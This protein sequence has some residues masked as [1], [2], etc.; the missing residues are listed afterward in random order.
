MQQVLHIPP[1]LR[2][3]AVHQSYGP[4]ISKYYEASSDVD[5]NLANRSIDIRSEYSS[6]VTEC[7]KALVEL[8]LIFPYNFL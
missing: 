2:S 7:Y 3:D 1:K 5:L 6:Q 4:I 8:V